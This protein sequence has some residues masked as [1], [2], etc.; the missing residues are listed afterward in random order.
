MAQKGGNSQ[1][2]SWGLNPTTGQPLVKN[3]SPHAG[4]HHTN[5]VGVG[6]AV[7]FSVGGS[8]LGTGVNPD[9]KTYAPEAV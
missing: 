3:I 4:A 2:Q 8:V 1:N 6:T 5:S 7:G 9:R